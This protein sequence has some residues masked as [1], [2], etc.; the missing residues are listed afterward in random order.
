VTNIDEKQIGQ[1]EGPCRGSGLAEAPIVGKDVI[2][3]KQILATRSRVCEL[4]ALA[5]TRVC[6]PTSPSHPHLRLAQQLIQ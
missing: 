5:Q 2:Q 3:N 6:Q 1:G 4:R